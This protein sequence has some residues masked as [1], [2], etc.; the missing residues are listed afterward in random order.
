MVKEVEE[1]V[2]VDCEVNKKVKEVVKNVVKKNKCV[3]CGLVKD[4]NYFVEGDVFF[5]II[6]VVFGDVEFI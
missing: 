5:V 4:V 6:D 1:K 2:K 3:F